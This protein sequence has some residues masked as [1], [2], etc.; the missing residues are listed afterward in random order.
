MKK[1]TDYWNSYNAHSYINKL[2]HAIRTL[3]GKI[4][5]ANSEML[6]KTATIA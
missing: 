4:L 2:S 3:V 6:A 5:F 1:F